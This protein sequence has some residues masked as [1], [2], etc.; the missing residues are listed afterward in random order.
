MAMLISPVATV[1]I[2]HFGTRITLLVGIFF[3]VLSLIGASFAKEIWQ[4]FLSQGVCFGWGMGFLFVS[5]VSVPPQWFTTRRSLANACAA[6]GSG[7]GALVYSLATNAIIENISLAWAFRIL[8][9]LVFVVNIV[10]AILI[11]DRNKQIGTKHVAFELSLFKKPQFVLVQGWGFF[12]MLGYVVLLFSLPNYAKQSLGLSPSQGSVINAILNLGQGLGRPPMGYFSDRVGRLNMAM[13]CT[14]LCG[15][16]TLVI[17][18]FA[19]SYGIL[20]FYA[21]VGGA[22]AGT[23]WATIAPVMAECIPLDQLPSALNISWLVLVLP[24]TFSEPIAL[25]MASKDAF[26]YLSAQI[27][28]GFMY[29]AAALCLYGVRIWKIGEVASKTKADKGLLR[30]MIAWQKV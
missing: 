22:V 1:L 9:I 5:S 29:I 7:L 18:V 19:N 3:E 28:T 16:F 6:A 21:L 23:Y 27:F 4:L 2:G 14:F 8:G 24:T 11:R 17:W 26:G 15:L 13:T 12:S 20:I 25:E 10:C 30:K